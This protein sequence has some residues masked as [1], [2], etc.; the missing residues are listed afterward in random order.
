MALERVLRV[1]HT[2][3][4]RLRE[5]LGVVERQV[6]PLAD[7]EPRAAHCERRVAVDQLCDLAR[8]RQQLVT[9]DDLGDEAELV[10]PLRAEALLLAEQRHPHRDVDRERTGDAH[11]LAPGHETD[12]HM[13]V[14]ELR[15]VRRDGDVTGRD[16][17]HARPTAD[18]VHCDDDR[19][20]HRAERRGRLLGRLPLLVLRQVGAF[21][22]CLAVRGD[23]LHVGARAEGAAVGGHDERPDV[24]VVLGPGVGV[25]ELARSSAR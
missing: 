2:L 4:E 9:F 13:G 16:Q 5:D 18:A 20:R 19:L 17:I 22:G 3:A 11:H 8:S 1:E 6:E 21:V 24:V 10:G 25:V 15:V 7:R 14:E 23:L 12:A